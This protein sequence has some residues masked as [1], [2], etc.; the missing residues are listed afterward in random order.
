MWTGKKYHLN[1]IYLFIFSHFAWLN[2]IFESRKNNPH[3][4][5]TFIVVKFSIYISSYIID[6]LPTPEDIN[7]IFYNLM[8]R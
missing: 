5:H 8:D 7:L 3:Y 1:T 4:Y 6:F 2:L